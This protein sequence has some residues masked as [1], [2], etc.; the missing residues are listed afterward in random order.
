MKHVT[1][2]VDITDYP[3]INSFCK[4]CPQQMFKY[5]VLDVNKDNRL[6][7]VHHK[8][9]KNASIIPYTSTLFCLFSAPASFPYKH[10]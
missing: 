3:P 10:I 9:K 1:K 5:Y 7:K 2:H 8:T 6:F 4:Q